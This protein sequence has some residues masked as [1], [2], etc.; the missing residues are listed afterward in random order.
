MDNR[1]GL[2]NKLWGIFREIAKNND[3]GF[4]KLPGQSCVSKD[5]D[6]IRVI[7]RQ[8]FSLK[9]IPIKYNK[10]ARAYHVKFNFTYKRN[11]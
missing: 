8:F 5:I 11:Y 10:K 2:P 9:E 4:V 7:L 6:R 3:G 1:K